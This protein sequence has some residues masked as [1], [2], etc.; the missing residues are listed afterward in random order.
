MIV[1]LFEKM[2]PYN[3]NCIVYFSLI[4][5]SLN[6]K[7]HL[8]DGM[9]TTHLLQFKTSLLHFFK[10]CYSIFKVSK[11]VKLIINETEIGHF[12]NYKNQKRTIIN[13]NT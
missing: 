9:V 13:Q 8:I 11:K 6:P 5:Q 3:R 4:L 12:M 2:R 7:I 1:D 10:L